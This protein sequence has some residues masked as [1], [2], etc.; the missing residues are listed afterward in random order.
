MRALVTGGA[1]FI[2]SHLSRRLLARGHAVVILDNLSTGRAENVPGD[3]SFIEADVADPHTLDRLADPRFDVVCHLAAQSSGPRSL[4]VPYLDFQTN[5][6]STLLLSNWCLAQGIP[7]FVYASS[8]ALYGNQPGEAVAE[9]AVCHPV[10]YYGVSK[11]TSENLL[12]LASARGL[13]VTSLRM[14][15]VYGPGQDL[16]NLHQGMV[17]IYLAYL[18]EG[19][20]VP[21][22][23]SL[24]RFRDLV[25]I[26]DVVDAW[27]AVLARSGTPARAYN[28]G[29]GR[30][31][32]VR[33]LLAA[34]IRTLGLPPTHPIREL[35]GSPFDQFGL[36]ADVTKAKA[37]LGW[38]ATVALDEGL[39]RMVAWA[40]SR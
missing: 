34:L 6:A 40:R 21:V 22:T 30:P 35:A 33:A 27:L 36:Y 26:D 4:D 3:A 5:A 37:D 23:G 31:T 32:T 17:S 10:S 12:G 18:L 20:A 8:M 13:R 1:G 39:R 2:G 38:T 14:F 7:S 9:T 28:L 19:V 25:Y 16:G 11:L 24:E 29:T 15:S